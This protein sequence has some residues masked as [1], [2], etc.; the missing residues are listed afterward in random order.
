M[1]SSNRNS[2][3]DSKFSE[4]RSDSI[5]DSRM[6]RAD[7]LHS[8]QKFGRV[9]PLSA[10]RRAAAKSKKKSPNAFQRLVKALGG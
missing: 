2:K 6:T 9:V 3:K 7:T 8:M 10:Q 5:L 4:A 1:P